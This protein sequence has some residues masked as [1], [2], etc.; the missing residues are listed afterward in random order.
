[1]K[2]YDIELSDLQIA[3]AYLKTELKKIVNKNRGGDAVGER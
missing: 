1:M 2:R 3:V